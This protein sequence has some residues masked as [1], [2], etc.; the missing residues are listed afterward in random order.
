MYFVTTNRAGYVLFCVTPSERAAVGL[1]EKQVV[2]LM[3]RDS[4]SDDWSV[5]RS[6]N[7][8]DF[9]HTEFM[10]K[11]HHAEEPSDPRKLLD[12]L[13]ANLPEA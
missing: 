11:L 9:S 6:W 10:V 4:G 13:P 2:Q 8:R 1:T 5:L 3:V 12:L 7:A